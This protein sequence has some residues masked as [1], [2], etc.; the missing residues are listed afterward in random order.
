[1][2]SLA[3]KDLPLD[4]Y[5]RRLFSRITLPSVESQNSKPKTKLVVQMTS[6]GF[7]LE[8]WIIKKAEQNFIIF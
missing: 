3:E 6:K 7:S 4:L 8:N 2:C 5:L 1:M